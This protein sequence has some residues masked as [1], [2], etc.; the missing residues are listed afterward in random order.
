MGGT[1]GGTRRADVGGLG[2]GEQAVAV[3]PPGTQRAVLRLQAV[4]EEDAGRYICE[5]LGEVGVAFDGTVLDVGCKS[6]STQAHLH[7]SL[8]R[9]RSCLLLPKAPLAPSSQVSQRGGVDAWY[10]QACKSL[11]GFPRARRREEAQ[12]VAEDQCRCYCMGH[13]GLGQDWGCKA[14]VMGL[15]GGGGWLLCV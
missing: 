8:S 1:P 15:G 6:L 3:F 2:A 13:D 5:A 4:R 9:L 14:Q 11:V 12:E 10:K 7:Q